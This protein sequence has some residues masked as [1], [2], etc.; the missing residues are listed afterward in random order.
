M[1]KAS[2]QWML[3][4]AAGMSAPEIA[5]RIAESARS[6]RDRAGFRRR[7]RPAG[8]PPD[9]AGPDAS[10]GLPVEPAAFDRIADRCR[11][12]WRAEVDRIRQEGWHFLGQDWPVVPPDRLW[13]LDPVTGEEWEADR[14]CFDIPYRHRTDMGDVK[15]VWEINRLQLVPV[16]A[17]LW[18]AEGREQDRALC[19]DLLESWLRRNPPWQGI[20]WCSGIEIA[21]RSVNMLAAA[22]LLGQL[23]EGLARGLRRSL[24]AHFAWLRRYPSRFSSANNHRIAELGALYV[25]GRQVPGLDPGGDI[26][27]RAL[28]E[29]GAEALRQI[30]P[31]GV[32]AEQSP[33]YTA[34]TLEW[35]L[36]VQNLARGQGD[37]LPPEALD[38]L[39]ASG[40]HLRCIMD[41]RGV[42]PRIGDDDEGR[43]FL[44]GP[45]REA[46]YPARVLEALSDNL[47]L[48]G[49]APPLRRPHLRQLW[50]GGEAPSVAPPASPT[51]AGL[52][53][54][55]K[56]GYSVLRAGAGETE[57][58]VV[59][60]HGPLGYLSI[61]AHGHADALSVWWHLGGRPV[62]VDAGTYLYHSGGAMRNRLRGTAV[63]NTLT[64][65]GQDQSRIAGP[66][67][68][69]RKAR[70]ER[71]P[72]RDG[73]HARHDGY[74][75]RHGVW[76]HRRLTQVADGG[77][78]L[79]DWLVP[80]RAGPLPPLPDAELTFLLH[81][82][83]TVER[84]A[85]GLLL[86]GAGGALTTVSATLGD[87]SVPLATGSAP[88]SPAFGTLRQ[89]VAIRLRR[90]AAEFAGRG[91]LCRFRP[92]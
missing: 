79:R 67:N 89:T 43:V 25:L 92:V 86:S 87:Q 50:L 32:G 34:F 90:P 39:A 44:S 5:H 6:G 81:P 84:V 69:S 77:F 24:G 42:V 36:L 52:S 17:A 19:L 11:T 83:L 57:S 61:A 80:R 4:R 46:D 12:E 66:F 71:L 70:A 29:L 1:D 65:G 14:F 72:S 30:H 75:R 26:A 82:D 56:G 53:H 48:P 18:R 23:P 49:L 13:H 41:C 33:S 55:D 47:A 60:D 76:H 2:L 74:L 28:A 22:G 21:L 68:W 85:T 78:A 10:F 54:F 58:L 3:R 37:S 40:R 62:L 38:R 15:Y 8:L 7:G 59:M 73:I 64:L 27:S 63:H 91:I 35:L 51:T 20:N 9:L 16:M 31:D 88:Y 45:A